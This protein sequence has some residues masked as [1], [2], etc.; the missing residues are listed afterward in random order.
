MT[1]LVTEAGKH[2]IP[3]FEM[4]MIRCFFQAFVGAFWCLWIDINPFNPENKILPF[5]R[6]LLG[7]ISAG[8]NSQM[9]KIKHQFLISS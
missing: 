7:P 1:L 9:I 8:K 2:G 4:V 6:G 3:S 5:L